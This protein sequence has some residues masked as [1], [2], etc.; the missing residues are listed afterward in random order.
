[1]KFASVFSAAALVVSI[2]ASAYATNSFFS[3]GP[4]D[5]ERPVGSKLH[6]D[7]WCIGD[8]VATANKDGVTE[9]LWDCSELSG[10]HRCVELTAQK[11]DW[12]VITATCQ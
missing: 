10:Q 6:Y 7:S 5:E 11:D 12:T 3:G 4:E 1:M 8:R 9:V 2:S